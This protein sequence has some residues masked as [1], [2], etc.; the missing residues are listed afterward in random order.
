MGTIESVLGAEEVIREPERKSTRFGT[1]I[2]DK[3]LSRKDKD[4]QRK[5]KE[6]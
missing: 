4:S 2:F 3:I 6:S 1:I 5:M